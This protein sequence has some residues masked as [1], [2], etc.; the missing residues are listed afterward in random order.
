MSSQK[1]QHKKEKQS[2]TNIQEILRLTWWNKRAPISSFPL[3][4]L[5]AMSFVNVMK[6]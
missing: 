5:I 6:V 1:S 3:L 2:Q 4:F